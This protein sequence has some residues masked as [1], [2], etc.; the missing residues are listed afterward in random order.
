M[1]ATVSVAVKAAI[2]GSRHTRWSGPSSRDHVSCRRCVSREFQVSRGCSWT[3]ARDE[4]CMR[5]RRGQITWPCTK[6]RRQ[7]WTG[8][9]DA[10]G[11]STFFLA[12]SLRPDFLLSFVTLNNCSSRSFPRLAFFFYSSL[13]R[14]CLFTSFFF[15]ISFLCSLASY[16]SFA[17][18]TKLAS[19]PN[20]RTTYSMSLFQ[21]HLLLLIISKPLY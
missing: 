4:T 16:I 2:S 15:S 7:S 8:R 12:R 18:M 21:T 14:A 1:S 5:G 3:R 20:V 13:T 6:P 19:D 11:W 10:P 9:Y 17:R